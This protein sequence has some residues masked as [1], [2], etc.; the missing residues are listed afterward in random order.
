ME[1]ELA[2][3][4]F[5]I[6]DVS[7]TRRNSNYLTVDIMRLSFCFRLQILILPGSVDTICTILWEEGISS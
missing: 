3:Q 4:R 2:L 1:I 6:M 5:P 7:D